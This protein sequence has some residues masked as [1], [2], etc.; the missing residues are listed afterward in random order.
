MG[1][2]DIY[3]ILTGIIL[4]TPYLHD[5]LMDICNL[6]M[7]NSNLPKKPTHLTKHLNKSWFHRNPWNPFFLKSAVSSYFFQFEKQTWPFLEF[8]KVKQF[9][10][11]FEPLSVMQN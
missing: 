11:I 4:L 10:Y 5:I 6:Y 7:Q 9:G 8:I 3:M 1:L 2:N